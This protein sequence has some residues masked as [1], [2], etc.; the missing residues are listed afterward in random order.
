MATPLKYRRIDC[1]V[2][3][4]Q[5]V[6]SFKL[7]G[8]KLQGELF[9]LKLKI[10]LDHETF[11]VIN[12]MDEASVCRNCYNSIC[13]HHEF[14]LQMRHSTDRYLAKG[15]A[16]LSKRCALSPITPEGAVK[17]SPQSADRPRRSRKELKLSSTCNKENKAPA[18]IDTTLS[19]TPIIDTD[20]TCTPITASVADI[21]IDHDYSHP[22]FKRN[23]STETDVLYLVKQSYI[24]SVKEENV[25]SSIL[26]EIKTQS[27]SLTSRTTMFASVLYKY[28][29][30]SQLTDN[31]DKLLQDINSSV[32]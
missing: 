21:P 6:T 8:R 19:V 3:F 2:C 29:D 28:R 27:S 11:D 32:R 15:S 16:L 18:Y 31:A 12:C 13:K 30:I 1:F 10:L 14:Y 20:S 4:S 24:E 23:T 9:Y 25:K 26:E 7:N 5:N 17:P 22:T